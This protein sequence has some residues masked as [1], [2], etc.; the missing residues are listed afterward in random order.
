MV[1]LSEIIRKAGEEKP[2][3]KKLIVAEAVKAKKELQTLPEI[4]KT[5]QNAILGIKQIMNDIRKGKTI[6]GRKVFNIAE[7]IVDTIKI[8]KNI[9]LSLINDFALYEN[10]EDYLYQ[11]SINAAILAASLGVAFGYGESELADLCASTLLH[12]IGILKVPKEIIMKPSKLTKEEDDQIKKHPDYGLE[13]LDQVKAPPK[14]ASEVIHQHH[15]RI[16]GTG[17][18]EGKK[19]K[20]ISKYAKIVAIVEVYEALTHPRPYHRNIPYEGAK[21]IVQEADASFEPE[22]VKLFLN[23]IT[24]YPPGSYVLLNNNEIGRVISINEGLPLRPAVEIVVDAEGN[25]PEK[26][27]TVDLSK[28]PVLNI[29]RALEDSKI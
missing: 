1:K 15:E 23:H 24:P 3:E 21:M 20:E 5:Y 14:S 16:D 6:E 22:L 13:L 8:N 12:D 10:E 17:Y 26:S 7:K 11:H 9:L 4:K 29:K 25:P 19:G 2:K 28:S 27:K 18:P